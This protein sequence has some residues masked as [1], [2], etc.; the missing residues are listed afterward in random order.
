MNFEQEL[1]ISLT[2][3]LTGLVVVFLMLVFLTLVIKGYGSTV[4]ALQAK[5]RKKQSK[6]IPSVSKTESVSAPPI[7][8]TVKEETP[9]IVE[10]GIPE[11]VLAV[12]A[13]AAY[14]VMPGGKITSVRRAARTGRSRSAWGMA[15]LLENTRPF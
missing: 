12:I 2:V 15:G 14:S 7:H 1:Q 3:L 9:Q 10:E 11:E 4:Q 8:E 6:Q 5:Y 13:A